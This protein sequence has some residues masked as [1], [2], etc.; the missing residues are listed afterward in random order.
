MGNTLVTNVENSILANAG[1]AK[2]VL[3]QIPMVV[4]NNGNLEVFGKY[5]VRYQQR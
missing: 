3:R 1:T 2:D 5:I 4:E